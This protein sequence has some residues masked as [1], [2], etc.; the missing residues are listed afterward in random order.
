MCGPFCVA[1]LCCGVL[2]CMCVNDCCDVVC[3]GWLRD[4]VCVQFVV[5]GCVSVWLV[6]S[7]VLCCVWVRCW[8][9]F[10]M[11]LVCV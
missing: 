3:L 10:D 2:C 4:C 7:V 1:G 8:F 6:M 5:C 9:V 11:W